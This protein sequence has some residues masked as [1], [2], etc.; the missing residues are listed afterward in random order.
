MEI[1]MKKGALYP[2]LSIG[3]IDIFN[4]DKNKGQKNLPG[5]HRE[6]RSQDLR[7]PCTITEGQ[8]TTSPQPYNLAWVP[9]Q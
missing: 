7:K 9:S 8:P 4:R 2:S 6:R 1:D 5:D 3:Y